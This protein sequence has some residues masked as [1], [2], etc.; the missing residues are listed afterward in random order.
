MSQK[1]KTAKNG[2]R[3]KGTASE[4]EEK[5]RDPETEAK[6]EGKKSQPIN[7]KAF[8]IF[9]AGGRERERKSGRIA[10][11]WLDPDQKEERNGES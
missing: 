9:I 11:D 8:A 7:N 3:K 2:S 5:N 1:V 6:E 10:L 4:E